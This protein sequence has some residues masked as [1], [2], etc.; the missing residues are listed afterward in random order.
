MN[1]TT[2]WKTI[3]GLYIILLINFIIFKFFGN[4]QDVINMAQDNYRNIHE[5]GGNR[6]NFIPFRTLKEYISNMNITSSF[7]NIIGNIIPFIPLGFL[8]PIVFP[9][10]KTFIKTMIICFIIIMLIE[11]IQLFTYLG[12]MDIDDVILNQISCMIGYIFYLSYIK[13]KNRLI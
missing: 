11:N 6:T 10:K 2:F 9:I 7:I 5:L 4:V 8:I 1:V 12:S 3:F 13:I